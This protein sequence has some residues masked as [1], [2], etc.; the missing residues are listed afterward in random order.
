V[1]GQQWKLGRHNLVGGVDV[2][3]DA[4]YLVT[5]SFDDFADDIQAVTIHYVWSA[6]GEVPNWE[7]ER[8]SRF[9]PAA[10]SEDEAA[11]V[12]SRTRT[13]RLPARVMTPEGTLTDRY[14][15]H[16]YFEYWQGGD[17]HYSPHFTEEIETHGGGL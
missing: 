8:V 12:R 1:G 9:M 6:L 10:H 4:E 14:L 15:L 13:L 7:Q 11:P 16:H 2:T 5:K 17:R 3:G